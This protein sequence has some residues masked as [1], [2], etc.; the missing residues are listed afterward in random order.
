[1]LQNRVAELL[2]QGENAK[3]MDRRTIHCELR[4]EVTTRGR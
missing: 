1:M 3:T 2:G 4:L